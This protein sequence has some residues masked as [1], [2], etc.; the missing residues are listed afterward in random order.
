MS[1]CHTM[2]AILILHK[3][4]PSYREYIEIGDMCDNVAWVEGAAGNASKV[5][6]IF[7]I[8]GLKK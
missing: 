6:G 3:L 8:A 5:G 4:L 7:S 1:Q 2:T